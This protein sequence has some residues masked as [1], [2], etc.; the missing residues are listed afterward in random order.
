M[1]A[2]T[3]VYLGWIPPNGSE[4][5]P[6]FRTIRVAGGYETVPTRWYAPRLAQYP[7]LELSLS[8]NPNPLDLPYILSRRTP[9]NRPDYE[10]NSRTLGLSYPNLDLFEYIGRTGGF[11]SGDPFSVCPIVEPNDDNKYSYEFGLRSVNNEVAKY[12]NGTTELKAITSIGQSTMITAD[13][14][15]LGELLPHFELFKNGISN[16]QLVNIGE[17]HQFGGG[18]IIISFDANINLYA[19]PCFDLVRTGATVGV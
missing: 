6:L 17:D 9:L 3:G 19:H 13:G 18:H 14:Q 11:F 7:G 1:Q 5:E 4:W 12:L 16:I 10:R 2:I 15:V 8:L